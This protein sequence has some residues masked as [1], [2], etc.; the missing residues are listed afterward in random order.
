MDVHIAAIRKD[1]LEIPLSAVQEGDEATAVSYADAIRKLKSIQGENGAAL[2]RRLP[3]PAPV[4]EV[5]IRRAEDT[6]AEEKQAV[7]QE[8]QASTLK[9][10]ALTAAVILLAGLLLVFALPS[11]LFRY[12]LVRHKRAKP[13]GDKAFYAYRAATFFLHQS[14]LFRGNLTPMRY[15]TRVVDPALGTSFTRFMQLYLKQKYAGQA[16]NKQEQQE[17]ATFLKSFLTTAR[18]RIKRTQRLKGFLNPAR[19]IS[20][21]FV[22]EEDPASES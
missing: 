18:T 3:D 15:A 12:Y 19:M 11:L 1:S 14:G 17:I 16:L 21:F 6:K 10:I 13:A 2:S 7:K 4:D 5:Y 22:Q 20:Y 8:P 9:D